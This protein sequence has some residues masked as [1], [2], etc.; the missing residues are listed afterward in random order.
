MKLN[1]KI[2]IMINMSNYNCQFKITF[3]KKK[4][5]TNYYQNKN[6]QT[7]RFIQKISKFKI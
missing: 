7:Y 2:N 1:T 4:K 3:N 6:N 5:L